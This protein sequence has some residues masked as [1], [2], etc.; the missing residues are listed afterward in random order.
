[1]RYLILFLCDL[2]ESHKNKA[3]SIREKESRDQIKSQ[4]LFHKH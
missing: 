3:D 2:A 1:M 4:E